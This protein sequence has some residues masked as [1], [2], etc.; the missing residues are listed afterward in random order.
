M[1]LSA[2]LLALGVLAFAGCG[3]STPFQGIMTGPTTS[4]TGNW[5]VA[6]TPASGSTALP[7]P[8]AAFIG[9]LVS[10]GSTIT[11]TMRALSSLASPCV[12]ILQD[13]SVTGTITSAN[14]LTLTIPI[15]G[16]TATV[17]GVL[18][19]SLQDFM[20]ATYTISGGTCAMPATIGS[21]VQFAPLTG[22]YTGTL[23]ESL[24]TSGPIAIATAVLSQSTAANA[25][26]MFPLSGTV[27]LTGVCATSFS[28]TDGAVFGDGVNTFYAV[29][30]PP[31]GLLRGAFAPAATTL[32]ANLA[33][34]TKACPVTLLQG[35]LTRQ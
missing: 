10:S 16:G 25:D 3:T 6:G 2:N 27:T 19:A 7:G 21:M 24:P 20:P 15:A 17:T 14:V 8:I 34:N 1:K 11:G 30:P 18:G 12:S 26:G 33:L 32:A 31:P 29:Y 23:T 13:L 35:T 4:V 22:T 5:E 28:F 9:S